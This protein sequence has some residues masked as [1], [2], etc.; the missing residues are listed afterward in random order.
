MPFPPQRQAS[1]GSPARPGMVSSSAPP[2]YRAK[3]K[4]PGEVDPVPQNNGRLTGPPMQTGAGAGSMFA[5]GRAGQRQGNPPRTPNMPMGGPGPMRVQGQPQSSVPMGTPSYPK[6]GPGPMRAS[7]QMQ[8][9]HPRG[10]PTATH[11]MADGGFGD[12]DPIGG[13][14]SDQDMAPDQGDTQP[15]GGGAGMP[16]GMVV[17][18]PEA[19][20]YHDDAQNCQ[21]CQHFGSDG[22]CEVLQ[23]SV[24]PDGGCTAFEA[25]A[26]GQ[27]D[28][29]MTP[30]MGGATDQNDDGTSGA[31]SLS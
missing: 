10:V 5:D 3:K 27:P 19:V 30:G 2:T 15:Q 7:G 26:G 29:G 25:G 13:T 6:A 9:A 11:M 28:Q 20:A 14:P 22:Q 16:G 21:G 31:P 1:T 24:S 8:G 12:P 17:I 23:M 18:K 4:K